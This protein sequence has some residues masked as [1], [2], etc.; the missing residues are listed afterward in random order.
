MFQDEARFGRISVPRPCWAPKGI[1]P[2]VPEQLIREYV[3]VYSAVSPKEGQ[4]DSLIL[5]DMYGGTLSIFLQEISSR[6]SNEDILMVMDNAPCHR[7]G[8]LLVPDN[9]TLL[10]LPPYSPSLNPQENIWDEMREKY[11]SNH[12]FDSMD[13][14]EQHL[15]QSILKTEGDNARLKSITNWSW[16][17]DAIR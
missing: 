14:L 7:S 4:M 2:E 10:P 6:Y 12:T 17:M 11:F 5:P 16:I 8:E 15:V 1:R 13:S 3:Y 9:I